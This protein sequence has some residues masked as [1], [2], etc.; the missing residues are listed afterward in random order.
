VWG[1][2]YA[3]GCS[4][5]PGKDPVPI[6]QEAG[7]APGPFWTSAENLAPT[8]IRSPDCPAHSQSLY[9]LRY[10]AHILRVGSSYIPV[11]IG[12]E[13]ITWSLIQCMSQWDVMCYYLGC[14]PHIVTWEF[15][16]SFVHPFCDGTTLCEITTDS[17]SF[18]VLYLLMCSWILHKKVNK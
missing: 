3:L 14:T 9:R 10:P 18:L 4:L 17:V 11:S 12:V 16:W 13:V 2:R 7:W 8:G 6:V 15:L 5:P 1:Q